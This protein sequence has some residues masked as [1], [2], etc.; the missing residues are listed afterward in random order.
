MSKKEKVYSV[1][2]E[3]NVL[4]EFNEEVLDGVPVL[5]QLVKHGVTERQIS[6]FLSDNP[7]ILIDPDRMIIVEVKNYDADLSASYST[8]KRIINSSVT[9]HI[10]EGD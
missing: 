10:T 4:N 6:E 5:Y 3:S 2:I 1:F 7:D 8:E 9:F